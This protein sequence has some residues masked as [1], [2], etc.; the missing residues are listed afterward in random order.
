MAVVTIISLAI[1]LLSYYMPRKRQKL[2]FQ[3]V[4][5]QYFEEEDYILPAE[6]E[7]SFRGERVT[8][9]AKALL[10]VWNGGTDVLRGE[11]IVQQDPLT[12]KLEGTGKI[13]SHSIV[14]VTSQGN[15]VLAIM[16]TDSQSEILLTYDYLNPGDG[17]VIQ[18][19]HDS[20]QRDLFLVGASKGLSGGPQSLGAVMHRDFEVPW[21][22]RILRV[23]RMILLVMFVFALAILLGG[24]FRTI[25]LMLDD[26]TWIP[27]Y[28]SWLFGDKGGNSET[29]WML[30]AGIGFLWFPISEIAKTRCRFPK[31][32]ERFLKGAKGA[33]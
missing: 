32:L 23:Q 16:R 30:V 24:V 31:S 29:V 14:G 4:S 17:A 18:V 12:I 20:K 15:R 7:M 1:A 6:V 2:Q 33:S 26:Y 19:M 8:R 21:I 11:D 28:A 27:H 10:I 5:V 9:L 3:T 13:L 25:P 22:Q